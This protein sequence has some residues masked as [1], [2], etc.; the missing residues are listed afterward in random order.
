MPDKP[1]SIVDRETLG[2]CMVMFNRLNALT[3]ENQAAENS[4]KPVAEFKMLVEQLTFLSFMSSF[5]RLTEVLDG[6]ERALA[7]AAGEAFLTK[8]GGESGL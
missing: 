8:I 4:G 7:I 1:H 3:Q 2:V 5:N 6:E